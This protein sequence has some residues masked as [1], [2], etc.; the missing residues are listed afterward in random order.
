MTGP[1][2][3]LHLQGGGVKFGAREETPVRTPDGA[4]AL[5]GSSRS[6]ETCQNLDVFQVEPI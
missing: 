5:S 6:G 1:A 2:L 3:R 4:R